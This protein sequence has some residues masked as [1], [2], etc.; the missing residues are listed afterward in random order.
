MP[1]Y[2]GDGVTAD[3]DIKTMD[4][5]ADQSIIIFGANGYVNSSGITG[6]VIGAFSINSYFQSTTWLYQLGSSSGL[7]SVE[8]ISAGLSQSIAGFSSP[9]AIATFNTQTGNLIHASA[10]T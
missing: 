9:L 4:Y 10:L 8:A 7:G 3:F 1:L 5:T 2:I 6:P